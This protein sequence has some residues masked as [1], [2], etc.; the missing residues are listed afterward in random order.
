MTAFFL[1]AL[2]FSGSAWADQRICGNV[3]L[4]EGSLSLSANEKILICGSP[5]GGEAWKSVPFT[6]AEYHLRVFLQNEGYPHPRFE[7]HGD[8]LWVWPG[9]RLRIRSFHINS[10]VEVI[11]T[12]TRRHVIGHPMSSNKL[13]EIQQWVETSLQSA[14]YP[15]AK[16][17]VR[18]QAW[19]Q[20]VVVN[21]KAGPRARIRRIDWDGRDGLDPRILQRYQ[22]FRTGE[23]Y[24][25][26]KSQLT[27]NRLFND[28]LFETAHVTPVC[29]GD[30]VNLRL[31]TSVGKPRLVTFG[32]GASTEEFPFLDVGYRNARLDAMAS[33]IHIG[34]HVSPRIQNLAVGSELYSFKNWPTL[35]WGPR[36]S[37]GRESEREFEVTQART[38]VDLGRYWDAW[39]SRFH[40]RGGP[41]LNFVNTVKGIGPEEASFVSWEA[42]LSAM[43]HVYEF[44]LREQYEGWTGRLEYRGQRDRL[45]SKLNVDRFDVKLKHLWNMGGFAPPLFVLASRAHAIGV[46][47][48]PVDLR[49]DQELLPLDYRIFW[50]GDQ[51]LRGFSRQ[52]LNNGEIGFLTGAY[53]GFELRLVEEFP[54]HLQPFALF[55]VA[56]LGARRFTLDPPVYLSWGGG[57]R[58]A[59]PI[60]T[61][62]FSAAKGEIENIDE[63]TLAYPK[64]WVY[65]FSFGQE[66]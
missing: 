16:V 19:N 51:N 53:A 62:R 5:K 61:I 42:A 32:I 14:G 57:V 4:K 27:M 9:P 52:R 18:A 39:D 50:G 47:A 29:E 23:V 60:G 24:D 12:Q 48:N 36:F 7:R 31:R 65:F 34:A 1:L 56:Q 49:S 26:R 21:V 59:S 37:A 20:H 22:A 66:F 10:D 54:F 43:S 30:H 46:N 17:E 38:G 15:C 44:N 33:S 2:L 8:E 41:T 25:Y 35:F 3:I 45:G 6:Q 58:W 40:L 13:N 11:S 63:T 64:E 28:G 55:D